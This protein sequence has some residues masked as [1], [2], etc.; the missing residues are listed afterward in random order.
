MRKHF[1]NKQTTAMPPG[2][3][4]NG[5]HQYSPHGIRLRGSLNSEKRSTFTATAERER[6]RDPEYFGFLIKKATGTNGLMITADWEDTGA[7]TLF[8]VCV[9]MQF[10][11]RSK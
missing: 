11:N 4:K 9:C 8:D 7:R 2:S 5:I 6:E 1:P 10:R 3:A